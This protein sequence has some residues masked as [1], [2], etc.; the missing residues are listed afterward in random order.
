MEGRGC[1]KKGVY[2]HAM[3]NVSKRII[4]SVVIGSTLTQ[5]KNER[6]SKF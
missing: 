3:L 2:P 5:V 6:K 4:D 1:F